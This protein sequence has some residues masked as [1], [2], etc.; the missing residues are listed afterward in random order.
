MD[1]MYG[2]DNS[3]YADFKAELVNDLQKGTLTNQIDDLNKI[4]I[5]ASR[6]VVVKTGKE[7]PGGATFA[8]VD[9][10]INKKPEPKDGNGKTKEQKYAECLAKMKCFNCGEKGHPA[11]AC[12]KKEKQEQEDEDEEEL[13]MAGMTAACCAT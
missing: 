12:P 9:T 6:R 8:T 11:K 4:Y 3:R 1:F 10:K 13:P 7:I 5:L 2:L